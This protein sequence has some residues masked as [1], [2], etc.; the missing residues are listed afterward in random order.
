MKTLVFANQKGGV[1]KSAITTQ[2]AFYLQSLGLRVLVI[3]LDH[4]GNTSRPLADSG[5]VTVASGTAADLLDGTLGAASLQGN[6]DLVPS[7]VA[8]TL[9]ER[10]ADQH[11]HMASNLSDFLSSVC[12]FDVCL[13][14]TNPNPDIRYVS[15]LVSADYVLAPIQLNQEAIEGLAGLVQHPQFGLERIRSVLNPKLVFI[16]ILPN[17]VEPT[18]FQRTNMVAVTRRFGSRL[19][20]RE[21]NGQVEYG[22]I[23]K[24][25]A[26]AEAQ[27]EAVFLP[28]LK[29]TSA[30]DAWKEIQ[31]VFDMILS[32]MGVSAPQTEDA[33]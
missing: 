6:F 18:P 19:L 14:D 22:F 4:Q 17:L 3:D 24:R 25:S 11:N 26:I 13:I 16:G 33:Q 7:H 27:A 32:A 1:G 2:L 20:R 28:D 29:K 30:R 5:R 31:P 12:D 9:C 10:K 21:H 23:P 15:A 8:L